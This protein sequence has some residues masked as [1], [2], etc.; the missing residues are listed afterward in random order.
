MPMCILFFWT[1]SLSDT[2]QNINIQVL[3]SFYPVIT[4][5]IKKIELYLDV[6]QHTRSGR[7]SFR[8]IWVLRNQEHTYRRVY[9]LAKLLSRYNC[10][11]HFLAVSV[12]LSVSLS[13][14][15]TI[16]LLFSLSLST[17]LSPYYFL[18]P[19]LIF[20]LPISLS[21]FLS[22]YVSFTF[23]SIPLSKLL[24]IYL[25]LSLSLS[26]GTNPCEGVTYW[27]PLTPVPYW[28]QVPIQQ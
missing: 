6:P 24:S 28:T 23:L 18:S 9:F 17:S 16:C 2:M 19:T 14:S 10:L 12:F 27:H 7:P 4:I 26:L 20:C 15:L 25:S 11:F 3:Y 13:L 21:F 8:Y 22:V 1:T 5:W